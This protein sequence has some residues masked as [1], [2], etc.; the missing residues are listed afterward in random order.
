MR[1]KEIAWQVVLT[2]NLFMSELQ[3]VNRCGQ[4]LLLVAMGKLLHFMIHVC[5]EGSHVLVAHRHCRNLLHH[6]PRHIYD[7]SSLVNDCIGW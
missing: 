7:L 4:L 2:Q 1:A 3:E 6:I 5:V